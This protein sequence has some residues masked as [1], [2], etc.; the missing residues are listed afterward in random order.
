MNDTLL[1]A[2]LDNISETRR[3]LERQENRLYALLVEQRISHNGR[4]RVSPA[5]PIPTFRR[6]PSR[7]RAP[8]PHP[9]AQSPI[10]PL[11]SIFAD[12]LR[13]IGTG[14]GTGSDWWDP[15][16]VT[17]TR[18]QID[19]AVERFQFSEISNPI[20]NVC[21]ITQTEFE[22]EDEVTRIT[23][24]GHIFGSEGLNEWF[25]RSSLCPV[26]RRDVRDVHEDD[27]DEEYVSGVR[28]SHP[29][30]PSHPSHHSIS[31]GRTFSP[32]LSTDIDSSIVVEVTDGSGNMIQRRNFNMD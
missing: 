16:S 20:S 8:S 26:C 27:L 30:H 24:C 2:Y 14:L 32:M 9:T 21:P 22:P 6:T 5:S 25:T 31:L 11:Q 3:F 13:D 23:G 17:P 29:S 7:R 28:M 19:R 18:E 4:P 15:V 12:L 10:D 1:R